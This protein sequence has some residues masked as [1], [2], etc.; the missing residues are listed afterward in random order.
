MQIEAESQDHPATPLFRSGSYR[1]QLTG[2][3]EVFPCIE[4]CLSQL[5]QQ[6]SRGELQWRSY[7][8]RSLREA[9]KQQRCI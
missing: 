9:P 4:K 5:P 1:C 8:Q 2:L 6:E 7:P 3:I